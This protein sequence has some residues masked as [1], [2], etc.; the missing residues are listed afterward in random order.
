MATSV[1]FHRIEYNAGINLGR[2]GYR[3]QMSI[4]FREEHMKRFAQHLFGPVL[5]LSLVLSAVPGHAVDSARVNVTV[6]FDFTVGDKQLKAGDYTIEPLLDKKVLMLRSKGGDVKQMVLTI[7]IET[8]TT[9]TFGNREHLLFLHDGDRY[10]LSQVW[11]RGD[12][13]CRDL[14]FIGTLVRPALSEVRLDFGTLRAIRKIWASFRGGDDHLLSGIGR[15]ME[16]QGFRMVGIKDA[17]P[18]LLMPEGCVTGAK[19]DQQALADIAKGRLVVPFKIALPSDAGF[20]LVSPQARAESAK[21]SAFRQW[22]R[23]SIQS[24][25]KIS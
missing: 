20:Y 21:L 2:L 11:F 8:P 22:L 18:D 25:A 9:T 14:L 23:A 5:G 15:I 17:A 16:G 12:E 13:G 19:P 24:G 10:S 7:P 1:I 3:R 6:P 4:V